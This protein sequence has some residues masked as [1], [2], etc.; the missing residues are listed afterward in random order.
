MAT[1]TALQLRGAGTPVEAISGNK[2]FLFGNP[3]SSSAYFTIETTK[4]GSTHVYDASSPKNASGSYGN[5]TNMDSKTL[6]TSSYIA[7]IEVPP[8]VTSFDFN[9]TTAIVV[10]SSFLRT[11]GDTTLT[12]S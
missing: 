9:P 5:F 1:Y 3:L 10:S 12:I 11:T 6:I 8:G 2:T 7:S 4:T